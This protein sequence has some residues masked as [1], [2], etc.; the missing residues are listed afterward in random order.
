MMKNFKISVFCSALLGV[1]VCYADLKPL[2]MPALSDSI[3]EARKDPSRFKTIKVDAKVA[4]DEIN[5]WSQQMSEHALFLHLGLEEPRLKAMALKLH[6]EFE[7]FIEKFRT[8][9]SNLDAILPLTKNL[10]AFKVKVLETLNTGKWIGWIFPLFAQ[11]IILELD[12][13]VDKLNGIPYSAHDEAVFWNTINGEHAGFE[14]HLLDPTERKL[15]ERADNFSKQF[16]QIVKS[17][18]EMFLQ[19]SLKS[20]REL[21]GYQKTL[22]RGI[23]GNTIRSVIHPVLIDHVIREDQRSI[24]TLSSLSDAQNAPAPQEAPA[25]ASTNGNNGAGAGN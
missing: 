9:K 25:S 18:E 23:Q 14:A 4:Q 17:E 16:A 8:T 10:R 6:K 1:G 2:P 5:F 15:S 19:I 24:K 3:L 21:N 13:F 22:Q 11:H 7:K 20:A 12:Y